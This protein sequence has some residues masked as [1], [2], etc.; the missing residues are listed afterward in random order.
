M[1]VYYWDRDAWYTEEEALPEN[2]YL[3]EYNEEAWVYFETDRYYEFDESL[4]LSVDYDTASE[5]LHGILFAADAYETESEEYYAIYHALLQKLDSEY[6]DSK[7][8]LARK[9]ERA[10]QE[11]GDEYGEVDA[12]ETVNILVT[13]DDYGNLIIAFYPR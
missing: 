4:M 6:D 11:A 2:N 12:S 5:K 13:K 10:T 9:I 3:E 7:L 8:S 1:E